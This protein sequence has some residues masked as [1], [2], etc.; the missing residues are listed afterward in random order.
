MKKTIIVNV[1]VSDQGKSDTLKRVTRK[2]I[3]FY[4]N[5]VIIPSQ[6]NYAVDITVMIQLSG[7]LIGIES[8]GDPNSNLFNSLPKFAAVNCDVIICACRTSGGTYGAVENMKSSHG[9]DIIRFTNYR[10][11]QKNQ[12][13]LN[14]LSSDHVFELLQAVLTGRI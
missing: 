4:P 2:I 1:G 9:Y 13:A 3:S 11:Y 7:I 12:D 6:L 8:Q 5:A 14:K 10:S